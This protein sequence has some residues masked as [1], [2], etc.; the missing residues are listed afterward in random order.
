MCI[1]DR[2]E[3]IIAAGKALGGVHFTR[4]DAAVHAAK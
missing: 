1:R 4:L 3:A 2:L